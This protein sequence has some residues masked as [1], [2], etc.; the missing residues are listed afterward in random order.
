MGVGSYI[1]LQRLWDLLCGLLLRSEAENGAFS[2]LGSEY[3][4]YH[5]SLPSA[6]SPEPGLSGPN[7]PRLTRRTCPYW[8][9][10]STIQRMSNIQQRIMVTRQW[11]TARLHRQIPAMLSVRTPSPKVRNQKRGCLVTLRPSWYVSRYVENMAMKTASTN[12]FSFLFLSSGQR[13]S[14]IYSYFT[15]ELAFVYC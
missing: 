9:I 5:S 7:A 12:S 8:V 10:T 11:L 14:P 4:V 2:L 1:W 6:S 15:L 13:G 3:V